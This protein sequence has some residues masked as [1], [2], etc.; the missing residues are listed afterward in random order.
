MSWREKLAKEK[1]NLVSF[2]VPLQAA[3]PRFYPKVGQK[4]TKSHGD[5]VHHLANSDAGILYSYSGGFLVY[6]SPALCFYVH[7][8][9]SFNWLIRAYLCP[10]SID[11]SF[12]I[13]CSTLTILYLNHDDMDTY[14]NKNPSDNPLESLETKSL[15]LNIRK[16]WITF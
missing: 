2:E 4:L 8:G 5:K 10:H 15:G 6:F 11:L 14:L 13:A 16:F 1:N 3:S 9:V 12:F 7:F